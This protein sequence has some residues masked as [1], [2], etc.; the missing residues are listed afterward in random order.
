MK[1]LNSLN[2][3]LHHSEHRVNSIMRIYKKTNNEIRELALCY[4]GMKKMQKGN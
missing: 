3:H 1:Q 4:W 2:H